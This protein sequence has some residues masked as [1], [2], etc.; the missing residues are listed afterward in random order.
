MTSTVPLDLPQHVESWVSRSGLS[1]LQ[2][3][4][5]KKIDTN[6]VYAFVERWH[7]ETSSFHMSFDEIN[8]TLDDVSCLLHLSIRGVF[9]SPRDVT[10]EVDVEL[11][12]DYL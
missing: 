10:E 2:R 5:L 3:T 8:I 9:W 1:S 4:S 6:L 7:S 11:V 12:V